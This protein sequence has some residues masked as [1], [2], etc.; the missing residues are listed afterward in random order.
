MP[1]KPEK[2]TPLTRERALAAALTIADTEGI[3]ALTMRRV[4]KELG[5]EAMA[6]YYHVANKDDLLDG[7]ID[8]VF[9]E[10]VV[11]GWK[12]GGNAPQLPGLSCFAIHGQ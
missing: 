10:I 12:R 9:G 1:R 5:V 6:L 11:T 2:R 3:G 7:M 8:L 4:A